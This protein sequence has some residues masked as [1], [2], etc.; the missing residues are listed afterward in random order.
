VQAPTQSSRERS[1]Y[2]DTKLATA[3]PVFHS[4]RTALATF[5]GSEMYVTILRLK[6]DSTG[7][8]RTW[9]ALGIP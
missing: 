2:Y 1:T 3:R 9:A 6:G 5:H 7:T 4:P 8:G